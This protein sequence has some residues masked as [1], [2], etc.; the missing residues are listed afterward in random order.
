MTIIIAR[1]TSGIP[2]SYLYFSSIPTQNLNNEW[3]QRQLGRRRRLTA[4]EWLWR[5]KLG[6]LQRMQLKKIGINW[7]HI[8]HKYIEFIDLTVNQRLLHRCAS[9]SCFAVCF[10]LYKKNSSKRRRCNL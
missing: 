4:N 10:G 2:A 9:C 7:H 5:I 3:L 6:R 8:Y 1:T